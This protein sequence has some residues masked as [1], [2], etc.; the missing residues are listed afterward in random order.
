MGFLI[1]NHFNCSI[2][3][4][5]TF[6][7]FENVVVCVQWCNYTLNF[8][9]IYRPPGA[10]VSVFLDDFMSF[11]GSV[12]SMSSSIIT[13]GD[14]NIHL[15]TNSHDSLNFKS[16][17][18]SCDL[19]QHID[20]PTHIHGHTLDCLITPSDFTGIAGICNLGCI[21]DH[22][23]IGC[24]LDFSSPPQHT[25]K[26][27][28]F[29]KYDTID[30]EQ[31]RCDLKKAAFVK[32]PSDNVSDLYEQYTNCLSS[33]LDKH[34]PP[35]TKTLRKPTPLWITDEYRDAKRLRRQAERR[36]RKCPCLLTRSKFRRSVSRC[37]A[38]INKAKGNFYTEVIDHNSADPNKLWRELNKILHR[39]SETILP[40]S[41]D[42]ESLANS[43]S[44][45]FINKIQ[46]IHNSFA[47]WSGHSVSPDISAP[48]LESFSPVTD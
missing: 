18:A 46:Q 40:Q 6:G 20:F 10:S 25:S 17:L 3:A 38:I 37:N 28:T 32:S 4:T 12:A 1:K 14:F 21:S 33:L 27:I 30:R 29:R 24:N 2:V 31:M 45:F 44:S 41:K 9:S 16:M 43:F 47:T 22:I 7:S 26:Y 5:P 11:S 39:K 19:V 35:K 34:A 13:C 36:W 42:D 48:H 23:S 15:Y 8:A